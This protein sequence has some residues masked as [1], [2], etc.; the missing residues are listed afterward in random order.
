MK[1]KNELNI[2]GEY[3]CENWTELKEQIESVLNFAIDSI[4]F[5]GGYVSYFT[6]KEEFIIS[7]IH[8]K[9]NTVLIENTFTRELL[10]TQNQFIHLDRENILENY[11]NLI[12]S[13]LKFERVSVQLLPIVEGNIK[14]ALCLLELQSENSILENKR[15]QLANIVANLIHFLG[16]SAFIKNQSDANTKL[17]AALAEAEEANLSKSRFL[18]SMSHDLRT[19]LNT[20]LGYSELI[21]DE[22]AGTEQ[23]IITDDLKI[24]NSAGYFLLNMINNL[25]DMANIEVGKMSVFREPI[26]LKVMIEEIKEHLDYQ[27]HKSKNTL[28]VEI[29][30]NLDLMY[31]DLDKVRSCIFNLIV[32]SNK[33]TKS[34]IITLKISSSR[35]N[36]EDWFHFEVSDNGSGLNKEELDKI[37][38]PLA[39]TRTTHESKYGGIGVGLSLVKQFSE[40]LGGDVRAES[41]PNK[42]TSFFLLLPSRK[43]EEVPSFEE[44][45][46]D[47][48]KSNR[49]HSK[50][51]FIIDDDLNIRGL[52]SKYMSKDGYSVFACATG[53]EAISSIK[54]LKPFVIT[55]DILLPDI[56]G[57]EILKNIKEDDEI[58]N[59]PVIVITSTLDKEKALSLNA[60]RFMSKP[61]QKEN[62][63]KVIR[64]FYEKDIVS[65]G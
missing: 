31:S 20:I 47:Y 28:V 59:I 60:D 36:N 25:I 5:S 41:E 34:G 58:K 40:M 2:N 3:L 52:L 10:N 29:E 49:G 38:I 57:W 30:D 21:Q 24:I 51:V 43:I 63:L 18:A 53:K 46:L 55:L 16:N 35:L 27:M 11:N 13:N 17:K 12:D 56:E 4:F 48:N 9:H 61:I 39:N 62:L 50:M 64:E 7:S 8:W 33:L 54:L 22:I 65:R 19:P 42:G 6:D 15:E 44:I 26:D 37:F 45:S 1:F 32:D 14:F 23:E